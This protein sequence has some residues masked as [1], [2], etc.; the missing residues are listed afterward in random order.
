MNKFTQFIDKSLKYA[1]VGVSR[2]PD[3]YGH[4]VFD[5]LRS[6]EFQLFP[7]NPN[8]RNIAGYKIYPTISDLPELVD[9]VVMVVPA[10]VGM[11]VVEE[12]ARLG[13]KKVWFQPGSESIELEKA[14]VELGLQCNFGQCI[15][16]ERRKID[17]L[18][19]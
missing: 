16:V 18:S 2:N 1:V 10:E 15:M 7:I 12:I 8:V 17:L 14:C 4:R 9:V 13:V 11:K 19:E 3:K 5:D 6:A